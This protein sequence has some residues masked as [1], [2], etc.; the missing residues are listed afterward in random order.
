MAEKKHCSSRSNEEKSSQ[1]SRCRT[2]HPF[3]DGTQDQAGARLK[4]Q[5]F[6]VGVHVCQR[7]H[8]GQRVVAQ[9]AA[10]HTNAP[11]FNCCE[12]TTITKTE[13]QMYNLDRK[14]NKP[15]KKG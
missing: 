3:H 6:A 5:D 13:E 10:Q 12:T 2:A 7:Q 4:N 8:L 1:G 9:V 14:K 11:R 15:K